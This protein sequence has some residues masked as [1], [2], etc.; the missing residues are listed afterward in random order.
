MALTPATMA[1]ALWIG[2]AAGKNHFSVEIGQGTSGGVNTDEFLQAQIEDGYTDANKFFLNG[3][4]NPVFR[5]SAA[6]GT[7]S[8]GTQH[9]RS[10]GKEYLADGTTRAHWDGRTGE[11]YMRGRSR[12]TT[13]TS[14]RPWIC[15]FQI[16]GS[17]DSPE[18]SDLVRV[19]TE[20]ANGTSTNLSIVARRSP[21]S[22]G[23]EIRT[24]L[25][26]GYNV[27]DWVNWEIRIDAG[28]L[29]IILDGVTVLDVTGMGQIGC[30]FK[31]GC[32]LQDSVGEGAS[33]SDWAAVET[34]KG[35]LQV[36][37][38]GYPA[39]TTPIFTG[40][41]D[42]L[43]AGTDTTPP[44]VPG[45]VAVIRGDTQATVTWEASTDNV[46]VA[47][48]KVRRSTGGG[49]G[50]T[51]KI[52]DSASSSASSTDKLAVTQASP[53]ATGKVTAGHARVW[54][55]SAGSTNT[56]LLIYADSAGAPGALLA[57][58]D[59]LAVS[60]TT[61]AVR[62][63]VFSGGNQITVTQGVNYWV[64]IGWDD[65]GTPSL[66]FSRDVNAN[67]RLEQTGF[68]YPT[69]PDP[70][71]TPSGSFSGPIDVW[72][73]TGGTTVVG[74]PTGTTYVDTGLTN[75]TQYG[76]TV[77]AVDA[78]ANESAQSDQVL[79]T[80]GAPDVTA[81]TV[82]TG[83]TATAGDRQVALSWTAST[84]ADT[85]VR[86]YR[87]YR[88][89][90][91][92][93]EPT[94]TSYVD[95]GL[96]NGVQRAYTVSAVD[97]SL[98]E[99]AQTSAANATPTAPP[100]GGVPFLEDELGTGAALGLEVA[101][102]ADL[103][104][105]PSTWT[106]TD[107]TEDVRQDPG[108]STSLG[109]NDESSSSNP[110]QLTLTL[111]NSAGDYS[112]GGRSRWWPYV[113]RN[114]PV[115]L[116][117]DPADLAGGRVV[118]FGGADGWTPGWDSLTG[119]IPVVTLSASG[120][121]RR[122][123]QGAA[124][125]QSA[126]RRAMTA[127]TTVQAYWPLEE[128]TL[129]AYAPAVRGGSDM[130]FV[131]E[132]DW[133][134]DSTF[135]C[136]ASLPQ[137][138][139]A[140]FDANVNPYPDTGAQQVRFL[141]LLPDDLASVPN[142]ATLARI[143]TTGTIARW[144]ITWGAPNSTLPSLGL[145]AYRDDGTLHTVSVIGFGINGRPGRLS[146]ELRQNGGDI[147]WQLGHTEAL[148]GAKSGYLTGTIVGKTAGA[149]SHIQ[150]NSSRNLG[151]TVVGHVTVENVITSLFT[152]TDALIA[153]QGEYASSGSVNPFVSRL[154]RL[155]SE[156]AVAL[157]RWRSAAAATT[158]GV[159]DFDTMGPQLVG[160]L[161]D[162]LREAEAADQGQLWDG[163]S[164]G[165][166]YTTRRRR[167]D[168]L[169][170]LTV[171]AAAG[172]LAAG[173]APADDDQRTRNRVEVKRTHGVTSV[174]ED[175]TGPLG[176][177]VIGIYDDSVTANIGRDQDVIQHAQWQVSLGTVQGYR[178]PSVTVDLRVAP[179]LA[180]AVL[181]IIPGER[182]D[183]VNLD[184]A[185]AGFTA[186]SVSLIVEGIAHEIT[187]KTWQ[188]T[189]RCS[190]FEPW[191]VGRVAAETGDTSD[192]AMRLDTD[193]ATLAAT[194]AKGATSLSV[195]TTGTGALWTT[196]ADDYPL[197]LSVGGLPV[198]A[199]ACSGSSSPQTMTVDPL[200]VARSSGAP[201]QLWEPRRV[202]MG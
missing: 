154:E 52:D 141:L 13:V 125:I 87:V 178:Y 58:S 143:S 121:L 60:A 12:I 77:S 202:G 70:F 20:G 4:F 80:P 78:A 42:G 38:T 166:S 55:S 127:L 111:D 160:P 128:G 44:T 134:S 109:R 82:P 169:V 137:M 72:V 103:T 187:A 6:A 65:P 100:I 142:G 151:E 162:L 157:T 117:I 69:F 98:N 76:Y 171:D 102:G 113:R 176:T 170:R 84:D 29:R 138:K 17:S 163:R 2:A 200:P 57:V 165:L 89:G 99:S 19:Q 174:W 108:I 161:L 120:T 64:G 188:V 104:A 193:G 22:G 164:H 129:A 83:L 126:F 132:P 79:V 159:H 150:L 35:S 197:T 36:W 175:A 41:D 107:V 149:V 27:N 14:N 145:W 189:F 119:R 139:D 122:L 53:T 10:E 153:F 8:T 115:R 201:V 63:Y 59:Q 155:C 33:S 182:L 5:I 66:T 168:G 73:E 97:N 50:T 92:I 158:D 15:F 11:H 194:A 185:L 95:I 49:V 9:P 61:E 96:T 131:G 148:P 51:G 135:F 90:A 191:A 152:N 192:M 181:D 147:A 48:Y 31:H 180:P 101:F 25:R 94:T 140:L 23:S 32:Y 75:G 26:T 144:D 136:S 67:Q 183:V 123:G 133:A 173:F 86:G 179:R 146:L 124:P 71:G 30:Y 68:A 116:R 34:Q 54:L 105:A 199:T 186:S 88:D 130:T 156:N 1:E 3:S 195:A 106:W 28:R 91:L 56:K 93:A 196:A 112:V 62:D 21:P 81:P 43:G 177:G 198:R 85:G 184:D 40:A 47:N 16:H 24:V 45:D 172:E 110:A 190:P 18:T 114:T 37:H 7:T 39:P 46:G 74:T 118:F 167:E